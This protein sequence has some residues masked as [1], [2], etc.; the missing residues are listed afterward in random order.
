MQHTV[1]FWEAKN[2]A[3]LDILVGIDRIFEQK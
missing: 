1:L 3:S 2:L